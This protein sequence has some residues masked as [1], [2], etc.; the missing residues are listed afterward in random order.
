MLAIF[1]AYILEILFGKPK[2]IFDPLRGLILFATKNRIT[3]IALSAFV[4]TVVC[5]SVKFLLFFNL[6][7]IVIYFALSIKD[8]KNKLISPDFNIAGADAEQI[9]KAKIEFIAINTV[10]NILGVLLYAFLGGPVLAWVYK[11]V[12]AIDDSLPENI[13]HSK[14]TGWFNRALAKALNYLPLRAC[15]FFVW[16]ASYFCKLDGKSSIKSA[17]NEGRANNAIAEASFAGSL[18]VQLGGLIYHNGLPKH[19][20]YVGKPAGELNPEQIQNALRLMYVSSAVFLSALIAI[21]YF[22]KVL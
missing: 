14:D 12:N 5:L 8:A 13:N 16:A 19:K 10:K 1:F 11:A 22:W 21:N 4:L 3:G 6:G 9:A 20:P 15:I 7:A 17:W 2:W 18:G